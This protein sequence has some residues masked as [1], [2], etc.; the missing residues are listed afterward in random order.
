MIRR[1]RAGSRITLGVLAALVAPL[2]YAQPEVTNGAAIARTPDAERDETAA[3]ATDSSAERWP[4][5][6]VWDLEVRIGVPPGTTF[7]DSLRSHGYGDVRIIP[8]LV[9]GLA[10]PTD[11][12]WLWVGG[13]VGVRGRTWDHAVRDWASLVA[14]DLLATVRA[15][16]LFGRHVE[17]GLAIGAGVGWIGTW[18]NDVM[19]DQIAPRLSV[20]GELAFR[21]GRAFAIGPRIGWDFFQGPSAVNAYGD[22]IEAGGP[23]F[24][25]SFEGR[26]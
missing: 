15:R 2:A 19:S 23:Y 7:D 10:F 8:A 3:D 5:S 14:A 26:E 11:I 1:V 25:L 13:E 24:G 20:Q 16:F 9:A 6:L 22:T 17:L 18:V 4:G 21:A 12:E